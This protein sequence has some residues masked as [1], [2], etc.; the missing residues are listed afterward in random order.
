M[1]RWHN[2]YP[3]YVS[4]SEK[5][6]R[7]ARALN[8]LKKKKGSIH[9][10][11][12]NGRTIASTWWGKSWNSNLE[13]Y[14]D[15]SNRIDRGRSYVRH[16]SVL[17]LQIN[18]GK[19]TAL[20]Q[21]T[22]SQPYRVEVTIKGIDKIKWQRMKKLCGDGLTSLQAFLSGKFP[23]DLADLFFTKDAGLFPSPREIDFSC[24]CPDWAHM[25]KH[26]AATLYGIGARLDEDPSL[27]FTLRNVKV[28]EL[29][30]GATK[31]RSRQ[32]LDKAKKKSG[33]ILE[34]DKLADLFGITVEETNPT[35]PAKKSI[36]KTAKPAANKPKPARQSAV[37]TQIP[38]LDQIYTIISRSRKGIGVGDLSR[39]SGLPASRIYPLIQRLK[40]QGKIENQA[41]GVYIAGRK[42]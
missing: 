23:S 19:V 36:K 37:K 38:P 41:R 31:N 25:C 34:D 8:R 11:I 32:L 35:P 6:A 1:A 5:K 42:P 16:G 39:K 7:A 3:P 14:A 13:R 27:F 10:I 15:Y 17:D 24:S 12:I 22:R 21:G 26:V 4:V 9:P 18:T 40:R 33:R 30:S 20:V 2:H 29:I 28:E